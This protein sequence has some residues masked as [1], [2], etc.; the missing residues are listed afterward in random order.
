MRQRGS[1]FLAGKN[2]LMGR[3]HT[4]FAV[5]DGLVSIGYKRKT[6]FDNKVIKKKVLHVVPA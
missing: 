1:D 5:R 2:V 3:D 4:L 6:H